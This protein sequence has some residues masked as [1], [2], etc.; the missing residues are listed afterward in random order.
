LPELEE[1]LT[2]K[3]FIFSYWFEQLFQWYSGNSSALQ[4]L[5]TYPDLSTE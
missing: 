4:V 3:E 2:N 5:E 1:F